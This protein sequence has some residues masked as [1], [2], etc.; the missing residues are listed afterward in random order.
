MWGSSQSSFRASETNLGDLPGGLVAKNPPPNAVD[1]GMNPSQG[2][3]IP[4][5]SRQLRPCV[6]MKIPHAA[7]KTQC[8]Q[9][10]K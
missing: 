6:A 8:I 1:A 9:M 2:I 5:A 10:N 4:Q 3:K 7:T